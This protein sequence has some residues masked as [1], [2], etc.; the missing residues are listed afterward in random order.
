MANKFTRI[1]DHP[2]KLSDI[3][4]VDLAPINSTTS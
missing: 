3:F 2:Y 4:N 1:T